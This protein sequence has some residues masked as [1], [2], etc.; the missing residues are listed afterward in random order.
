MKADYNIQLELKKE[1]RNKIFNK[2]RE[3][4]EISA[5][6]L[7]NELHLSRPTV[8]QN[9]VELLEEGYIYESGSMGYT[10]GRRAKEYSP[11]A[12][13][14][15]ALGVDLTRNHI[16]VIMADLCGGMIYNKRVRKE[17]VRDDGYCRLLGEL[18]KEAVEDQQ[19]K[20]EAV[21]G[22]GIAIP[23]LVNELHQ[24]VFYGEI[25]DF[26]GMTAEEIGKYIP[27]PCRLYND[28]DAAGYAEI[29]QNSTLTDAFYISL[30]NNIGGAVLIDHKVYRGEGF[31]SGEIGHM[32]VVEGGR[33]CYCGQKGCFE[34]YCNA[35][36]LAE[37]YGGNL[38]AFFDKLERGDHRCTARWEEY[39]KYLAMAVNN[40]RML[41][42]CK[43]IIGGYVGGR[44][45]K[46]LPR[47]KEM[48]EKR[49]TFGT[50]AGYLSACKVK[51]EALALGSA[52]PFIHQCW[53]NI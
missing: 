46:H 39:M 23:G 51:K 50:G 16:T 37:E 17:F 8:K 12:K 40:V 6:L 42:D 5:P 33:E 4:K 22:V 31:R 49:N 15:V 53:K 11:V 52:L 27:Y 20:E 19:V 43:V 35:A 38:D 36:S 13:S 26:T 9:L 7:T 14:R 24:T 10:G 41:F 48:V 29:S 45:E 18:V 34:A 30:S 25:L 1:N 47:L 28:A 32:T 2:I 44:F 3:A 21:L